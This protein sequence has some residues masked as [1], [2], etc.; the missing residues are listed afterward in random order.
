MFAPLPVE[1]AFVTK[2]KGLN[3]ETISKND[4]LEKFQTIGA[5]KLLLKLESVL[6][7]KNRKRKKRK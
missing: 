4:N 3:R 7:V 5:R 2:A 1:A 6:V